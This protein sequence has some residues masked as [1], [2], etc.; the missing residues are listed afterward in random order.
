M[1]PVRDTQ[2]P[3]RQLV[4]GIGA[5]SGSGETLQ[6]SPQ[7][8]KETS[9]EPWKPE[10]SSR[11]V[12]DLVVSSA[13][14]TEDQSEDPARPVGDLEGAPCGR[15]SRFEAHRSSVL[16]H[17]AMFGFIGPGTN[18]DRAVVLSIIRWAPSLKLSN[19][20]P[21]SPRAGRGRND[22]GCRLLSGRLPRAAA[23]GGPRTTGA[24]RKLSY[25]VKTIFCPASPSGPE[26][27]GASDEAVGDA[28][29]KIVS[30]RRVWGCEAGGVP[31]HVVTV[32]RTSSVHGSNSIEE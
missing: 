9:A 13:C 21:E 18:Q 1:I 22:S 30:S 3:P 26:L 5:P 29:Q 27:S 10:V 11:P 2:E 19:F 6:R 4:G 12:G 7:D 14:V 15:A 28:G 20:S 8:S 25:G 24:K 32:V 16:T 31:T 23:P 17:S